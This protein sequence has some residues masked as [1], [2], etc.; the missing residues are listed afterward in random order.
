MRWASLKDN[1]I[2]IKIL[3]MLYNLKVIKIKTEIVN[4]T[5]DW[6]RSQLI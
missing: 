4:K 1:V 5:S 3:I 2:I 6:L